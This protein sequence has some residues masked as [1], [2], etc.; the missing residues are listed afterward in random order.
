MCEPPNKKTKADK[1]AQF[2]IFYNEL[3]NSINESLPTERNA[4][5]DNNLPTDKEG[6]L[7]EVRESYK[8]IEDYRRRGM[9]YYVHFGLVLAKLKFMY[10]TKCSFCAVKR[11][12]PDLFKILSCSRC[13][14]I[15]NSSEFFSTVKEIVKYANSYINFLIN[16]A[17]LCAYFPKFML[18]SKTLPEIK[19]HMSFLPAQ[20]EK[21]IQKW[22]RA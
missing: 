14:H 22:V 20:M 21:D 8:S 5:D 13:I 2:Q 7:C 15:S 6:L 9:A 11:P 4:F 16:L 19:Q 12:E 1:E 3:L 17:A 10:F 18:T